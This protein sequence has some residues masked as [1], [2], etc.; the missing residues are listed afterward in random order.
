MPGGRPEFRRERKR[1]QLERAACAA[2]NVC[3]LPRV[4]SR[5]PLGGHSSPV[6]Q[7]WSFAAEVGVQSIGPCAAASL[8]AHPS[9]PWAMRWLWLALLCAPV[10]LAHGGPPSEHL[11]GPCVTFDDALN[12]PI[13]GWNRHEDVFLAVHERCAPGYP[14]SIAFMT[15]GTGV[16]SGGYALDQYQRYFSLWGR[17]GTWDLWV[18]EG[19]WRHVTGQTVKVDAFPPWIKEFG[20]DSFCVNGY[21]SH[22]TLYIGKSSRIGT[23]ATDNASGIGLYRVFGD[24]VLLVEATSNSIWIPDVLNEGPHEL[25][26]EAQDRA[27]WV[28]ER[29]RRSAFVD[30]TAPEVQ[31]T[32][33]PT[34]CAIWLSQPQVCGNSAIGVPFT[35]VVSTSGKLEFSGVAE[36]LAAGVRM[37]RIVAQ[38]LWTSGFEVARQYTSGPFNIS[39]APDGWDMPYMGVYD[40][41]IDDRVGNSVS[42]RYVV[43]AIPP[44]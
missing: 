19:T 20:C 41:V 44:P 12:E 18:K 42:E 1:R 33:P 43:W 14:L 39:W 25:E 2:S 36:D 29:T 26:L 32:I 27:S 8:K 13:N 30:R 11:S 6:D 28:S 31:M 4:R 35:T 7:S 21:E 40:L 10:A 17:D 34:Q 16:A 24:G 22:G 23:R 15:S 38:P 9:I 3:R 37:V 5:C